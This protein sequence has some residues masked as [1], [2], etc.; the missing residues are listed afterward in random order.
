MT[1]AEELKLQGNDRFKAGDYAVAIVQYSQ[2]IDILQAENKKDSVIYA[3]RSNAHFQLGDFLEARNDAQLAIENDPNYVKGYWRMAEICSCTLK[4][5][6]ALENYRKAHD[7]M[8]KNKMIA[9]KLINVTNFIKATH[10]PKPKVSFFTALAG[11]PSRSFQP[12]QSNQQAQPQQ[13][14]SNMNN[15]FAN[16]FGTTGT[17]PAVVDESGRDF[18]IPEKIT[19][20]FT[21][22]SQQIEFLSRLFNY[23]AQQKVLH[24][25]QLYKLMTQLGQLLDPIPAIYKAEVSDPKVVFVGDLHG[26]IQDFIILFTKKCSIEALVQK[27]TTMVILGDYVDRGPHGHQIFCFL[28]ALKLLCPTKVYLMRGNHE[29]AQ[30]N[31]FFGY[32]AQVETYYGTKSGV[33]PLLCN[34]FA[35]LPLMLFLHNTVKNE[36]YGCFHGGAPINSTN[37][38]IE[39]FLNANVQ[40]CLE[41]S[42][43][44]SQQLLWSDPQPMDDQ[45]RMSHRGVGYCYGKTAYG[46]FASRI[47]LA[48]V[49]RGHEVVFERGGV[50]D[51]FGNQTHYTVFSS[52]NYMGQGNIGGIAQVD[53]AT[54]LVEIQ[55]LLMT[56]K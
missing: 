4:H 35:A 26:S 20:E 10:E 41:P 28:S 39:Q 47:G 38:S 7:L 52:S 32:Q 44:I 22:E 49:F 11:I 54:G 23:C 16:P 18:H 55:P 27:K 15:Q 1:T 45:V 37:N 50:R 21:T 3:N 12:A 51:D 29:T 36:Y 14:Y 9:E 31:N 6:E 30:M 8:P 2:A 34:V 24:S 13:Q 53:T 46:Q 19:E 48:K 43:Q 17:A 40:K 42:D 33:F 25:E 5:E 56:A